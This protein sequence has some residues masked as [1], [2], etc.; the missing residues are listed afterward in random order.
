MY[1][2]YLT[3]E[4]TPIQLEHTQHVIQLDS[5]QITYQVFKQLFYSTDAFNIS[6]NPQYLSFI[7]FKQ[8]TVNQTPF[9]LHETILANA[10]DD[11]HLPQACFTVDSVVE[12]TQELVALKSL[13]EMNTKITS[14]LSWQILQDIINQQGSGD[15]LVTIGVVFKTPTKDVKPTLVN[16][17][18]I[19]TDY[20]F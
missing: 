11:L 2:A 15:I 9:S 5:I 18:Y 8:Q 20:P 7:S 13:G 16:F 3:T 1:I 4:C 12:L 10:S 17:N 19:I 14:S 6:N